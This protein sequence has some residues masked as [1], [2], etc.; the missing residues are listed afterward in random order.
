MNLNQRKVLVTGGTAGIG[1]ALVEQLVQKR[2]QVIVCGRQQPALDALGKRPGLFP[3]RCDLTDPQDVM[4]LAQRVREEH[5]DL[6]VLVN[7][8]GVQHEVRI[9]GSDRALLQ[10][11]AAREI[12][13]NF[14]APATLTVQ[15]LETLGRQQAAAIVNITTPLTLSPKMSSPFYCATKAA[16]RLFTKSL[17]FQLEQDCPNVRLIEAQ[18]PLVDTAMTRGRGAGK[19]SADQAAAA[20][21]AGIERGKQ[22]IYVGKAKLLR[23]L[24][25][26][27]PF[28]AE[29]ITKAW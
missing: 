6:S 11:I 1:A 27:V 26:L 14:A 9:V 20:I 12:E 17:R 7:N 3:I 28:V 23:W 15:L 5:P 8:A 22:E 29:R 16:L 25:R 24:H 2:C 10:Q 4:R 13:V 18:P 19:I 21:I